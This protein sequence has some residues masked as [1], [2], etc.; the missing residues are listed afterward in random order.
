MALP[1]IG[2]VG[3]CPISKATPEVLP[4]SAGPWK[5]A[6]VAGPVRPSKVIVQVK[7]LLVVSY[8]RSAVPL[9]LLSFVGTSWAASSLAWNL[10]VW[11]YAEEVVVKNAA[12]T[13]PRMGR[14]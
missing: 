9:P 12:S 5:C 11:A 14:S 10:S 4:G 8:M 3:F 7:F 1:L 13:G 6:T 2:L